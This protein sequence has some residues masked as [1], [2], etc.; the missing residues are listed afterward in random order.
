VLLATSTSGNSENVL[1]ALRAAK[2]ME[3]KTIAL[4]GKDGGQAKLVADLAIVI[5]SDSTARIQEAHIL[6]GHIL[7]DLIEQ[8]LGIV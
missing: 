6:I 7:C 2:E 5:P 8:E 4:L 1:R 3:V